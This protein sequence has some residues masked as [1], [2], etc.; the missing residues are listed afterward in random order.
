M[1]HGGELLED[2]RPRFRKL[3]VLVARQNGKTELLVVLSL[4]WL[5]VEQVPTVLGTSTNL[6]YAKES[7]EKA[8]ELAEGVPDLSGEIGRVR[9]AAGEE[10]LVTGDGCRYKIAASNRKGGRSLTVGRLVLDELREHQDWTAW[11]AA[12]PAMNAVPGAQAWAISNQGDDK[13]VVLESLRSSALEH[14]EA[15]VGDDRLG[16]FEWSA[17]DGSNPLDVDALS[18]ANPNLG[19]RIEVDSLLGDAHRAASAGGD[20]LAGFKTEI[21]C[22]RVP[23]FD[24]AIDPG[25]W[26]E[27]LDTGDMSQVRSRV[28][29]CVDVA[30]DGKHASLVAAAMLPD[31]RVRVETVAAWDGDD[32]TAQL[33]RDLPD[34]VRRVKPQKMGWFPSGPAASVAAELADRNRSGWPPK[35]VEVDEIR[36]EV[37]QVCMGLSEQVESRNLAHSDDPLLNAQLTSSEK[38]YRGD[39]WVFTRK[40]A[41]HCDATYAT[42]GAVHLARTL[43]PGKSRP[44]VV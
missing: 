9:R 5:F 4:F 10:S 30:L 29:L 23:M 43:P 6:G 42:A 41:G 37:A 25:R 12:V 17:P 39:S 24:S 2:G 15:G 21:M 28:A 34:H 44:M 16:L 18:Q 19:N 14:I 11:N 26:G 38:S 7:F 8:V 1:I 40:G 32:C 13:S 27:C 35:G 36:G 33:R 3:L 22:M 20:E 31:D